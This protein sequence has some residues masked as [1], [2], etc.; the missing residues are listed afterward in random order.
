MTPLWLK[1]VVLI[2]SGVL[3]FFFLLF[4][5]AHVVE[6]AIQLMN[7]TGP[8][9]PTSESLLGRIMVISMCMI[10]FLALMVMIAV[11]KGIDSRDKS[12]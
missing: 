10:G 12:S 3:S 9:I 5:F 2:I 8:D 4:G 6:A 1:I 7:G 11:I